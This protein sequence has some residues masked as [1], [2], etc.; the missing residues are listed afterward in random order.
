MPQ[1]AGASLV[2]AT[3]AVSSAMTNA[4][5]TALCSQAAVA[6]ITHQ[7]NLGRA[8]D[9]LANQDFLKSLGIA[10]AT[11]GLNKTV[12]PVA[13]RVAMGIATKQKPQDILVSI[14]VDRIAS[15]I[16]NKIGQA[17]FD[18]LTHK[19]ALIASDILH[20]PIENCFIEIGY[21]GLYIKMECF[22]TL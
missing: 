2:G 8:A 7:G 18:Y 13:S 10:V 6:F 3:G 19:I 17:K 21:T 11:A 14:A 9:S 5:F 22:S 1:G 16:A 12:G 15:N 4:A 20:T